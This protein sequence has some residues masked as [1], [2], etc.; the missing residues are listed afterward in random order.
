VTQY[1]AV[2]DG[3]PTSAEAAPALREAAACYD[4][5]GQPALATRMLA[6]AAH[7]P[8]LASQASQLLAARAR[9]TP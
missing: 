4:H 1:R 7:V 5:M 2:V 6:Q 9:F 8:A 3:Y